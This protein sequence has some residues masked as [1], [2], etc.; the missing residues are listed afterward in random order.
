MVELAPDKLDFENIKLRNQRNNDAWKLN[1]IL[2]NSNEI[3]LNW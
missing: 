2:R 1:Y 3:W